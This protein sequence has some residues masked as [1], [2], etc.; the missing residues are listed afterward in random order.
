[1]GSVADWGGPAVPDGRVC[2]WTGFGGSV[3]VNDLD[4]NTTIAYGM[5]KL[6]RPLIG[7]PNC[8][9]Y[10]EAAYTALDA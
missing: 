1:M 5:N 4:R 6:Q 2:W 10:L 9:A 8:R 3:V 7:A